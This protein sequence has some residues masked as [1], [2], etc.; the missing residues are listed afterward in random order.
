MIVAFGAFGLGAVVG[1]LITLRG[2]EALGARTAAARAADAAWMMTAA[3]GA[4][5]GAWFIGSW[6][7]AAGAVVGA[8][9]GGGLCAA[10]PAMGAAQAAV[11]RQTHRGREG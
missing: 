10:A 1:A 3:A 7:G 9:I 6:P 11:N 8:I 5:A 4:G 2:R